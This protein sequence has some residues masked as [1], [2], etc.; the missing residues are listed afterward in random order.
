M[1]FWRILMRVKPTWVPRDVQ[2]RRDPMTIPVTPAQ[3]QVQA[4]MI[5]D[6]PAIQRAISRMAA[7]IAHDYRD[8]LPVYLTIMH[9]ALPFAGQLAIALGSLGQDVTF[10]YVHATRY[11]GQTLGDDILDEGHTLQGV[12]DWCL[13]QQALDVRIA[14]LAVKRH[15]RCVAGLTADYAGVDVPDRYVF[16]FGMDCNE[17]LRTLPAIYALR[18]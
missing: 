10:D 17:R 7:A 6:Q 11:R 12:R 3:A 2:L 9:G 1:A 16:G 14:V 5:A 18:D 13:S 15:D 4:D 8:Q